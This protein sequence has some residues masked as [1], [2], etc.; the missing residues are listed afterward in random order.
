MVYDTV[1]C[2]SSKHNDI[3]LKAIRSIHLF[4]RSRKIFVIT[5]HRNF[6]YFENSLDP[7][8]PVHLL[9]EDKLIKDVNLRIIQEIFIQRTGFSGR[10]GW[11]FQQF[12]KM[13]VC[14]LSDV[15]DYYLIWDSDTVLLKVIEFFDKDGRVLVNPKTEY[16]QPYFDLLEKV[17]GIKRQVDF[18]FITEHFMINKAYMKEL[19]GNLSREAQRDTSWVEFILN[20]IDEKNL[21]GSG[22]SEYETYGNFI[23]LNY[24]NSFNCRPIKSTRYG[25]KLYGRK[26][27]L[28]DIFCLMQE[29]Y[30][31]ATFENWHSSP[32]TEISKNKDNSKIRFTYCHQKNCCTEQ[33]NAAAEI[34]RLPMSTVDR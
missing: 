3:A 12:L 31:F 13:A 20:C 6:N 14:N 11:Y 27:S 25:A 2:V 5:P 8:I 1:L 21:E 9:N 4:S 32:A 16:H 33:L 23:A 30:E 7:C 34:C 18:S 15:A 22:F 17:L 29:G 10:A 24:S 19:I 26:P 28:Y